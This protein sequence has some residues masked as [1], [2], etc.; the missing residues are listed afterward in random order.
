M[1]NPLVYI[2]PSSHRLI[3]V[4]PYFPQMLTSCTAVC[5][6]THEARRQPGKSIKT[7]TLGF[8]LLLLSQRGQ[9]FGLFQAARLWAHHML[10]RLG[11]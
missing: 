7:K 2:P 9:W 1:L 3:S 8:G 11:G 6:P 5:D 4:A 10:L